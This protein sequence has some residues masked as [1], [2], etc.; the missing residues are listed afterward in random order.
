MEKPPQIVPRSSLHKNLSL[1]HAL[2]E[3]SKKKKIYRERLYF[4]WKPCRGK[5]PPG[6]P[7]NAE[8]SC[9]AGALHPFHMFNADLGG[10]R[11]PQL[12]SWELS[13]GSLTLPQASQPSHTAFVLGFPTPNITAVLVSCKASK[14]GWLPWVH[15]LPGRR[16]PLT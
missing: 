7:G 9:S 15:A 10:S 11:A 4:K 5:P 12:S 1:S 14:Q 3:H 16:G 2:Q 13:C 6:Q 8:G